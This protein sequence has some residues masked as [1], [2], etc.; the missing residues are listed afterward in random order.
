LMET[1]IRYSESVLPCKTNAPV[2]DRSVHKFK[3][4]AARSSWPYSYDKLSEECHFNPVFKQGN[5]QLM[6]H[7]LSFLI[8]CIANYCAYHRAFEKSQRRFLKPFSRTIPKVLIN[9]DDILFRCK[10]SDYRHWE[11]SVHET[12]FVLSP[13]KNYVTDKFMQVN[14]EL[15]VPSIVSYNNY[16]GTD[17]PQYRCVDL[18]KVPYVN[19]GL[20]TNRRKNDCS[21]DYS[22]MIVE[23]RKVNKD[24]QAPEWAQRLLSAP[25]IYKTLVHD[26]PEDLCDRLNL[27][28]DNHQKTFRE[29]LGISFGPTPDWRVSKSRTMDE[30]SYRKF[31]KTALEEPGYDR[32]WYKLFPECLALRRTEVKYRNKIQFCRA[33]KKAFSKAKVKIGAETTQGNN[34][35]LLWV[36]A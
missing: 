5:G 30:S 19:F 24:E 7:I 8:L 21:E 29:T 17:I 1:R 35:S 26:L 22:K 16:E 13:G 20:L 23:S 10:R 2:D 4:E 25:S 14:S 31:V 6:G 15:W 36:R 9:G 11:K 28:W 33:A 3:E 27:V 18:K 32:S 12:G 34:D